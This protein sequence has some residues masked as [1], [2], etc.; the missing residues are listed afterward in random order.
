L[1]LKLLRTLGSGVFGF[2]LFITLDFEALG[3]DWFKTLDSEV[4]GLEP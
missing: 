2:G 1:G 3:P 4:F